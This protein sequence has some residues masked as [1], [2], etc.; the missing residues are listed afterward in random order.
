MILIKGSIADKNCKVNT[1][2]Y[3]KDPKPGNLKG[4]ISKIICLY[5]RTKKVQSV[6][7]TEVKFPN[8]HDLHGLKMMVIE[9]LTIC[10]NFACDW[11][12]TMGE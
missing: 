11:S 10:I 9:Y 5:L 2:L 1:Q 7:G 8:I 4:K 6:V 3:Q 12:R